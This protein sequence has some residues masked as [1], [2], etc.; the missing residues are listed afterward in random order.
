MVS[1]VFPTLTAPFVRS[2]SYCC[3]WIIFF[4]CLCNPE[5]AHRV[6]TGPGF[7]CFCPLLQKSWWL[8]AQSYKAGGNGSSCGPYRKYAS[9]C[10]KI[11]ASYML[12]HVSA[13]I[14][15]AFFQLISF[16]LFSKGPMASDLQ[17]NTHRLSVE[18]HNSSFFQLS[19]VC[20]FLNFDFF[21]SCQRW[22]AYQFRQNQNR[23]W[24]SVWKK[25]KIKSTKGW[26]GMWFLKKHCYSSMGTT[27]VFPTSYF[28]L[29][30]WLTEWR[31]V[32]CSS[33]SPPSELSL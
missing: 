4:F 28:K 13:G 29:G 18:N 32:Y 7:S 19:T 3:T 27:W 11:L 17:L 24:T 8:Q 33:P 22:I 20:P 31:E 9:G 23:H 30:L 2:Q 26:S 6:L 15:L 5:L 16:Y 12:L 14:Y 10:S 1:L 25:I 21:G